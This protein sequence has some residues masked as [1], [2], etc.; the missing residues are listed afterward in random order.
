MAMTNQIP[1]APRISRAARARRRRRMLR[2]RAFLLSSA[3]FLIFLCGVTISAAIERFPL[4]QVDPGPAPA[5]AESPPGSPAPA[6]RTQAPS[7]AA[8][9]VHAIP[10]A[11]G[12]ALSGPEDQAAGYDYSQ[13][14]PQSQPGQAD[15]FSNS[16]FFGNSITEGVGRFGIVP[17]ATVYAKNGL[18]V[19][20]AL[21]EPIVPQQNG[22]I[23]AA[24][25]LEQRSFDKIYLMFGMNELGWDN[26]QIFIQRYS[27][28]V[29]Q[30]WQLQPEAV[31]YVQSILPVTAE[32]SA[33]DTYF[34]NERVEYFNQLLRQ[35]CA[36]KHA[37]FLDI[38]AALA[39]ETGAL[40]QDAAGPDGIHIKKSAYTLWYDY[41]RTH[42]WGGIRQ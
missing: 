38:H 11:G 42:I 3:L 5:E 19:S 15:D 24:Q 32:K 27:Q 17:G 14:V 30:V 7:L 31:V 20:N 23:T 2:R 25:A 12:P 13:P 40:P 6:S 4:R 34:T 16:L 1:P 18:M 22:H 33:D 10:L 26:E 28:L 39:D 35:M 37:L 36:E 21:T 9:M 8:A 41:V 29:D